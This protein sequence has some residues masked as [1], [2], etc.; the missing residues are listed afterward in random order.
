MVMVTFFK[1]FLA[2]AE[3]FVLTEEL[4][5]AQKAAIT[6]APANNTFFIFELICFDFVEWENPTQFNAVSYLAVLCR[7]KPSDIIQARSKVL[8]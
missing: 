5:V 7:A 4:A 1:T 3:A 6:K 2:V 8:A